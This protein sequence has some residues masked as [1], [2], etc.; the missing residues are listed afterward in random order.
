MDSQEQFLYAHFTMLLSDENLEKVKK[1]DE[2]LYLI[3]AEKPCAYTT[4]KY[5]IIEFLVLS[6]DP[7]DLDL[8]VL[9][10]SM[11][12]LIIHED[13]THCFCMIE[14][15]IDELGRIFCWDNAG[16][17]VMGELLS[18]GDKTILLKKKQ[19]SLKLKGDIKI[20][21][22]SKDKEEYISIENHAKELF[23]FEG[24]V[25]FGEGQKSEGIWWPFLLE[26]E[27]GFSI[28]VQRKAEEEEKEKTTNS[29]KTPSPWDKDDDSGYYRYP[30]YDYYDDYDDIPAWYR[31]RDW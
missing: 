19:T 10:N 13:C 9:L 17:M 8:E 23:N 6:D 3:L 27:G 1:T 7:E 28:V 5:S 20:D 31:E 16:T 4:D 14:D 24:K 11:G 18:A 2:D 21:I 15:D 29:D 25:I 30:Y 26:Q 22:G 12:G